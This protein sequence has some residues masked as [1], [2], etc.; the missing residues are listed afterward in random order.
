MMDIHHQY[1][2]NLPIED[3]PPNIIHR[4]R[5]YNE[6]VWYMNRRGIGEKM[7]ARLPKCIED[8]VQETFPE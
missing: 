3:Q 7:R 5:M 4:I 6:F 1:Y 2:D 8:G